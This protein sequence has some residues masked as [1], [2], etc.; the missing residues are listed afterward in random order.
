MVDIWNNYSTLLE[1]A[2]GL[3]EYGAERLVK[4]IEI[5]GC[6]TSNDPT[7]NRLI[8]KVAN[9]ISKRKSEAEGSLVLLRR[10][11]NSTLIVIIL[12]SFAFLV[13]LL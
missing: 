7:Y 11:Q 6:I 5:A 10:A 1:K 9:F 13:K 4:M 2:E 3:G 12:K 8:E